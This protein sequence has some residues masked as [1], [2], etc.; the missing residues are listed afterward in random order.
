MQKLRREIEFLERGMQRVRMRLNRIQKHP[1][2]TPTTSLRGI[3]PK[4]LIGPEYHDYPENDCYREQMIH[5]H[6]INPEQNNLIEKQISADALLSRQLQEE[7]R[8]QALNQ[9]KQLKYDV[10]SVHHIDRLQVKMESNDGQL[11]GTDY[12]PFVR[13]FMAYQAPNYHNRQEI[14]NPTFRVPS[15]YFQV[16]TNLQTGNVIGSYHITQPRVTSNYL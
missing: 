6:A 14:E 15:G 16:K 10:P 4:Q 8:N 12:K 2:L 9:N 7:E 5:E 1:L 11:Q 3:K 13:S